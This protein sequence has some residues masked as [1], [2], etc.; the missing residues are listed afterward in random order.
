ME[1]T[2]T[3]HS[4]FTSDDSKGTCVILSA[5]V[6]VTVAGIELPQ[7]QKSTVFFDTQKLPKELAV[8]KV[9]TLSSQQAET[10][11]VTRF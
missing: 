7:S 3:K 5:T 2:I 4:P 8:G 10:L 11:G 9:I 1:Y 6:K